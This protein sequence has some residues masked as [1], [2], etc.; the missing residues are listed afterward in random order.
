MPS[1][2]PQSLKM[3][4]P[5]AVN[6]LVR[7]VEKKEGL[8]FFPSQKAHAKSLISSS[9]ESLVNLTKDAAY[10]CYIGGTGGGDSNAARCLSTAMNEISRHPAYISFKD[11]VLKSIGTV[12]LSFD[13]G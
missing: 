2:D 5:K 8:R 6:Q 10:R 11:E 12:F 7:L 1:F 13:L 9:Y 3:D 4:S